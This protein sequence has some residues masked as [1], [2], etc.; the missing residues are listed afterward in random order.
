[1]DTVKKFFQ[2]LNEKILYV[3]L[4]HT[5]WLTA[6]RWFS[7]TIKGR[8]NIPCNKPILIVSR[9]RGWW[10]IPLLGLCFPPEQSIHYIARLGLGWL[11][12]AVFG[13]FITPISR[14]RFKARHL[15]RIEKALKRHPRLVIFPEGTAHAIPN[16]KAKRGVIAIATRYKLEIMPVNI[17]I[18]GPYHRTLIHPDYWTKKTQISISIGKPI[19]VSELA[20]RIKADSF[21]RLPVSTQQYLIAQ[22]LMRVIDES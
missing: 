1:M 11:L 20:A 17:K 19:T 22:E 12:Y 15:R 5:A 16:K 8:E 2:W 4:W 13:Y 14:D 6:A 9:H 3:S 18:T 10:D 21:L 7:L